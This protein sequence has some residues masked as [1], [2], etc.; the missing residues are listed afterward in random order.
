M[1]GYFIT[2][3]DVTDPEGLDGYRRVVGTTLQRH[4]A[5]VLVASKGD[6]MEGAARQV[7]IVLE[8]P[9]VEAAH[10]WYD[11]PDYQA[12]LPGRLDNTSNGTAIIVDQFAAPS[13]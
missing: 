12:I 4:Q 9:S 11:D 5:K 10:A 8:F 6:Q 3:Y 1:A 2:S 7:T 13:G